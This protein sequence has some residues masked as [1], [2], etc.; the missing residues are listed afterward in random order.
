MFTGLGECYCYDVFYIGNQCK[1]W[2][3]QKYPFIHCAI[4]SYMIFYMMPWSRKLALHQMKC[5]SW[6][7]V[8]N[9]TPSLCLQNL[10][11]ALET[12]IMH[13]SIIQ[14]CSQ[15]WKMSVSGAHTHTHTHTHTHRQTF[16]LTLT[17]TGNFQSS[18]HLLCIFELW[19]ETGAPGG[20]PQGEH[21]LSQKTALNW[22]ED[23][24][25]APP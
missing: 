3:F 10:C 8:L 9:D 22:R 15:G 12:K 21:E 24:N 4:H 6:E 7:N 13:P 11:A 19:V 17:P 2:W 25:P 16:T 20:N 18:I 1:H 23:S 14:H 5:I